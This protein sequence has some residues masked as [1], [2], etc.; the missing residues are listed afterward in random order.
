MTK[1]CGITIAFVV[2]CAFAQ[3]VN[4]DV[5]YYLVD[6]IATK[7]TN[8]D[9]RAEAHELEEIYADM[10]RQSGVDAKLVWS[11]NPDV[12]AFAT[13]VGKEKIVVVQ[14]GLLSMMNGDRDAVA[15]VLGHELGHHKADHIRAGKRKE[16]GARVLG[17]LLGAVVGAKLGK[18]TGAVAGAAVGNVGGS[19][20]ALKFDRDQEMEADRLSVGWMIAAGYNP[21][22]MLRLQQRLAAMDTH[23]HAAILSTHPTSEKRYKAAEQLIAKLSPPQEIVSQPIRPLVGDGE[24]ASASAEIKGI[25]DAQIAKALG[26]SEPPSSEA[27]APVQK[28]SFD[29]YATL[30][31]QLDFA[32]S[33]GRAHVLATNHV[34]EK[35]FKQAEE[36]FGAR[37]ERDD[38]LARRYGVDYFRASQGKFANYG[39]DLADS[40]EKS[41]SLHLDPPYPLETASALYAEMQ[42]RGAPAF[43]DAAQAKA[44]SEVLKPHGLTYYDYVIAHNWWMRKANVAMVSGDGSLMRKYLGLASEDD[45][46]EKPSQGNVH[47]GANVHIGGKPVTT[48]PASHDHQ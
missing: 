26:A 45:D 19:L 25:E 41:Q 31:S 39:R 40:F 37:I 47:I 6:A 21:Q 2:A 18:G 1:F 22:G 27:L 42:K 8:A 32:G 33:K 14:E 11:T 46:D 29:S 48:E 16:E 3:S 17:T 4:A 43:D 5:H 30:D 23:S 15:A 28:L 13:E 9:L 34:T 44:E 38:A 7:S 36:I 20:V 24:L 10:E 12:N 35:Q